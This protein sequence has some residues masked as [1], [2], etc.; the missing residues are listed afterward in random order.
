MI[1]WLGSVLQLSVEREPEVK[2]GRD[3]LFIYFIII[4]K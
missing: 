4:F 3:L 1:P 2:A